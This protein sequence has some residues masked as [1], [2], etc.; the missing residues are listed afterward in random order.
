MIAINFNGVIR[1][2]IV[3]KGELDE[4]LFNHSVTQ[5]NIC[6][7]VI[8]EVQGTYENAPIALVNIA[9]IDRTTKERFDIV[10]DT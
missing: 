1:M 3:N 7:G 8:G 4:W 5:G 6:D 2:K 10:Y 9:Y